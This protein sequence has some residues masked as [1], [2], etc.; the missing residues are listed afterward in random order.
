MANN[1]RSF[2]GFESGQNTE[3][4]GTTAGA[5]VGVSNAHVRTGDWALRIHPSA[6]SA[7]YAS[8]SGTAGGFYAAG[9]F[10][11]VTLPSANGSIIFDFGNG[12]SS[13]HITCDTNGDLKIVGSTTSAVFGTVATGQYY[14]LDVHV[15]QNGTS[16][17]SLNG[18][19]TQSCTSPN[20]SHLQFY[21]G[22][23]SGTAYTYD[24]HYDDMVAHDNDLTGTDYY[25]HRMDPVGAGT[26]A[27]GWTAGTGST[28]AEVDEGAPTAGVVG[29]GDTTYL[30]TTVTTDIMTFTVE[31]SISVG[32]RSTINGVS[33]MIWA[34]RVGGTVA[35]VKMRVRA[36]GSNRDITGGSLTTTYDLGANQANQYD[37]DPTGAAWSVA[38]LDAAEVGPGVGGALGSPTIRVTMVCLTVLSS[39]SVQTNPQTSTPGKVSLVLTT[40]APTVS[41][42]RLVTPGVA[43]LTLTKFAP[44]VNVSKTVI[45]DTAS[46]IIT[47]FA[48]TISEPVTAVISTASLVITTYPPTVHASSSGGK[49][50]GMIM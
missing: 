34:R 15:I 18:G 21:A 31:S 24:I 49:S 38:N 22:N 26:Y 27:T 41:T 40:F 6:Q 45:P 9:Y 35:S 19:A 42:P 10:Y 1:V 20:V 30:A 44:N 23:R 36:N 14:R 3:L 47:T 8:I 16:T 2:T 28:F 17:A 43:S 50:Y 11:V 32:V 13:T 46:L 39:G 25:V 5:N 48:P 12:A 37:N 7:H 4:S 29:D 33:G